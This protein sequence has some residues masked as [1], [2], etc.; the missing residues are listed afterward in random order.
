MRITLQSFFGNKR[1][2]GY[3]DEDPFLQNSHSYRVVEEEEEVYHRYRRTSIEYRV[4]Q[5][6]KYATIRT[7]EPD[8]LSMI[9]LSSEKTR[10]FSSLHEMDGSSRLVGHFAACEERSIKLG[11]VKLDY[12]SYQ[13]NLVLFRRFGFG[14]NTSVTPLDTEEVD[15]C[16]EFSDD[17]DKEDGDSSSIRYRL[18]GGM[19]A[20]SWILEH[21][22]SFFR[23][24]LRG[25]Q[26]GLCSVSRCDFC[27]DHSEDLMAH[28]SKDVANRVARGRH[29]HLVGYGVSNNKRFERVRLGARSSE[30]DELV[31]YTDF[32]V[33][34]LYCGNPKTSSCVVM[35]Y[36]KKEEQMSS[37]GATFMDHTRAEIRLYPGK[38]N[39]RDYEALVNLFIYSL[40]LPRETGW[41]Q[42]LRHCVYTYV[43]FSH[44]TFSRKK[45]QSGLSYLDITSWSPWY[46]TLFNAHMA[47]CS[48]KPKGEA[49]FLLDG[50]L[51]VEDLLPL[52]SA[53]RINP[54]ND[55]HECN[56][57]QKS[58]STLN[59]PVVSPFQPLL[60]TCIASSRC[61][62][63]FANRGRPQ[64]SRDSSRFAN[65]GRPEGSRDS[66]K[67]ANRGRPEGSKDSSKFANRGRPRLPANKG[68]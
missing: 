38:E 48:V 28:I 49:P 4:G 37:L 68:C 10:L 45:R 66:S 40:T 29:G 59:E 56:S 5:S 53:F 2:S 57:V 62:S 43:Q 21:D 27:V 17:V 3:H 25:I 1:C 50:V 52:L 22:A 34:S 8:G 54:C 44:M 30:C 46:R 60:D 64:G 39:A 16:N 23:V 18:H 20:C 47:Y 19:S 11:Q 26:L 41:G 51:R 32:R 24:I 15:T 61:T 58:I 13:G 12:T 63:K 6:E 9:N 33:H 36:D 31:K 65:R 42:Y 35:F 14:D 55:V 67:F 7:C